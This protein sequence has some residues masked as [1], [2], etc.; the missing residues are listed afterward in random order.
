MAKWCNILCYWLFRR[1]LTVDELLASDL[2][3]SDD[4][5]TTGEGAPLVKKK[6]RKQFSVWRIWRLL[7]LCFYS[8]AAAHKS[9]L[10]NLAQS[11]PEFYQ[12]LLSEDQELLDFDEGD[13][14]DDF[15]QSDEAGDSDDEEAT[16]TPVILTA[17][18][19][20]WLVLS[21]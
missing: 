13:A 9:D 12:F 10:A 1:R 3:Q 7:L 18:V 4:D 11:D 14:S 16:T 2:T 20:N 15:Y 6:K 5:V 8:E 21:R 19:I 17:F